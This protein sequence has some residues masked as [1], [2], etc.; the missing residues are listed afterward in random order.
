MPNYDDEQRRRATGAAVNPGV[1]D[2]LMGA[3]RAGQGRCSQYGYQM[4]QRPAPSVRRT[5]SNAPPVRTWAPNPNPGRYDSG[6]IEVGPGLGSHFPGS[7]DESDYAGRR[8]G[9][10]GGGLS[11]GQEMELMQNGYTDI[12]DIRYVLDRTTGQVTQTPRPG[13]DYWRDDLGYEGYG[14]QPP[15]SLMDAVGGPGRPPRR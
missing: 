4:S 7:Y 1:L 15:I 13:S 14:G 10:L 6:T 3:L 5:I 9:F 12:G 11:G 8:G 2:Q